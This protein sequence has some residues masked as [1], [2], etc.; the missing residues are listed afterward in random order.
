[1]KKSLLVL[2]VVAVIISCTGR[3]PKNQETLSDKEAAKWFQ[4]GEWKS[5]WAV[6]PDESIDQKEFAA[7]YFKNRERWEKAFSFLKDSDL[8]NM[9]LGK[10]ELDGDNLF[11]TVSEYTTKNEEDSRYEAHR[12]Y[13]DIQYLICGQERI[14]IAALDSITMLAPYDSLKDFISLNTTKPVYFDASPEKFFIFF[15]D[16]AHSPG[17]KKGEN[18]KVRKVVVKVRIN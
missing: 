15:P 2:T 7:Q 5:G 16:D 4:A 12:K 9:S 8:K 11:A 18:S 13:A 10:H 17:V 3:S 14:G 1:M 6:K